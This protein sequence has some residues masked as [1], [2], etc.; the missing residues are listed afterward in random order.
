MQQDPHDQAEASPGTPPPPPPVPPVT[1]KETDSRADEHSTRS[2][3]TLAAD[4]DA[5]Q[6]GR[7][8]RAFNVGATVGVVV[9]VPAVIFVIQNGQSTQFDW[10]WFDFELPLWT[11]F[12]GGIAI[13]AALLAALLLVH[14]HRQRRIEHRQQA[15]GRLRRALSA[16]RQRPAQRRDRLGRASRG[17]T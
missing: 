17:H 6:R 7:P 9:T 15:G 3:T 2:E 13:G 4:L 5:V 1:G 16:S 11:V 10:L 8:E 12:I 14:R